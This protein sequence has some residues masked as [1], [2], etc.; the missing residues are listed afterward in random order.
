LPF[1]GLRTTDPEVRWAD[2]GAWLS[3]PD[4]RLADPLRTT[5]RNVG[6][7]DAGV[8]SSN[9][10]RWLA[11]AGIRLT[12]PDGR[13]ANPNCGLTQ[14]TGLL[15]YGGWVLSYSRSR[16]NG[17][18]TPGFLPPRFGLRRGFRMLRCRFAAMIRSPYSVLV[19]LP[20]PVMPEDGGLSDDHLVWLDGSFRGA[21][22]LQ[23]KKD[24]HYS[25]TWKME[26]P[27]RAKP[28]P[29][30]RPSDA[31]R[32]AAQLRVASELARKHAYPLRLFQ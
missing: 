27:S 18:R 30:A 24:N 3:N 20:F 6:S 21:T 23:G 28:H 29:P 2:I 12:D 9:P 32:A 16:R 15:T 13:M 31:P 4:G 8:W 26:P 19:R 17:G 22:I 1:G 14:A 5:D 11:D 25:T 10:Y 7:A